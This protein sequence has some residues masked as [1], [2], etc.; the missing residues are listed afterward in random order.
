MI[1]TFK[2]HPLIAIPDA[3]LALGFRDES[4]RNDSC[5]RGFIPLVLDAPITDETEGF[6]VWVAE[7]KREDREYEEIPRFGLER[8]LHLSSSEVGPILYEGES[9]DDLL[10]ALA[11]ERA[12]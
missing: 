7:E 4:Y 2:E 11:R 10:L 9:L 6:W 8:G 12:R 5:G 3:L 1:T